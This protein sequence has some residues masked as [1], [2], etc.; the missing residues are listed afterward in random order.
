MTNTERVIAYLA[1]IA[2]K[3]ASNA[4]IR[5]ATG[6]KPHQQVFQITDRLMKEGTIKGRQFG[7][8]WQFWIAAHPPA[9]QDG[10]EAQAKGCC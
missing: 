2:P 3:A 1:S 8:E 10:R 6:V 4:D 5:S 9:R 7:K